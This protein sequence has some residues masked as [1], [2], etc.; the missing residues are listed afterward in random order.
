MSS[1][2]PPSVVPDDGFMEWMDAD[3][4]RPVLLA[5]AL[6]YAH[7]RDVAE[8]LVQEA[9]LRF[10]ANPS[11]IKRSARGLL[12]ACLRSAW[13]DR[14]RADKRQGYTVV[15]LTDDIPAPPLRYVRDPDT[16]TMYPLPNAEQIHSWDFQCPA[17]GAW[18]A[19]GCKCS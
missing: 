9:Y 19:D 14:I 8:D 17:C 15:P 13:V 10:I 1:Y 3:E 16:G 18:L 12:F 4:Y 11:P 2:S 5:K 6:T 7:D